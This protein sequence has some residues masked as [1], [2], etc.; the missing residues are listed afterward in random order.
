MSVFRKVSL[1]RLS[2]PEQLDQ[3]IT[4]TAPR[5][6][7]SLLAIAAILVTVVF[8][9]IF[10]SIPSKTQGQGIIV[11]SGGIY[12]LVHVSAGQITDVRVKAGDYV[13]KGDVVAR[14]D[15]YELVEKI[16]GLKAV[17]SQVKALQQVQLT[18]AGGSMEN[19]L[20]QLRQLNRR[21][22]QAKATSSY[23]EEFNDLKHELINA[24]VQLL[25]Y[26][27]NEREQASDV[28][29]L[30]QL[31]E[32]GAVPQEE[33]L[34][35]QKELSLLQVQ[36]QG[37]EVAVDRTLST[38]SAKVTDTEEAIKKAQDE[39][40]LKSAIV[41]EEEGRVLEVIVNQ[42]DL[43]QPGSKIVSIE[44]AGEAIQGLEAVLY[45]PAQEGKKILPGMTAQISPTIVNKEEHGF[46]LGRV[47]SVS[48]YPAT[49]Q[50]MMNTLGNEE[51]VKQLAG[52]GAPLEVH[53]DLIVDTA[54]VSGYKW[55]TP[56]GP[57]ILI[58]SGT[59]CAGSI[60]VQEQQPIRM[61]IPLVK[62]Y[63]PI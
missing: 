41:S 56:K 36:T 46:L 58:S 23:E 13:K 30:I 17:L 60:T 5:A 6:W 21:I 9:S 8:W 47:V 34:K 16:N 7:F 12:N 27:I 28:A 63:L 48:E 38:I 32:A 49:G 14:I 4:V 37:A 11:K 3:M 52:Q 44:K 51:L 45:I 26:Q 2:S 20:E 29:R 35:G 57:P 24:K 25:Q 55:S 53:V 15:Q 22:E 42:G 19:E 18:T 43:I 40:Q 33:L 54:T 31:V 39:L 10:G 59:M 50:A 61:V 62:K 1:E